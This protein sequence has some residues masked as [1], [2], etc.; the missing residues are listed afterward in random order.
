MAQVR[1]T[2][3]VERTTL[4]RKLL[5]RAAGAR[6]VVVLEG[7]APAAPQEPDGSG[8][9]VPVDGP[10]PLGSI[11]DLPPVSLE[12]GYDTARSGEEASA[13]DVADGPTPISIDR[14]LAA[15]L[16]RADLEPDDRARPYEEIRRELRLV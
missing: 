2:S 10:R 16:R 13:P 6:T 4:F 12:L 5:S 11:P 1:N 15:D 8:A 9:P 14:G 7:P 3:G